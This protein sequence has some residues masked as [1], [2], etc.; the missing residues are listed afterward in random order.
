MSVFRVKAR[1][2][3][4]HFDGQRLH[5]C[6][7]KLYD[8]TEYNKRTWDLFLRWLLSNPIGD[9]TKETL[10]NCELSKIKSLKTSSDRKGRAV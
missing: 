9:T 7:S 6:C 5:V 2:S 1:I 4:V 10:P 8:F 3:Q